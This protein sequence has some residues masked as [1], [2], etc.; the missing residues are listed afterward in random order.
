LQAGYVELLKP[1]LVA[2]QKRLEN[3]A[4]TLDDELHQ[5]AITAQEHQLFA[6]RLRNFRQLQ[7]K[8]EGL[9]PLAEK[10]F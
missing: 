10:L 9:L 8:L 6:E 4:R 7:Q 3:I 5:G 2:S 1:R